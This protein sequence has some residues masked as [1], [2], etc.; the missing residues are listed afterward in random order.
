MVKEEGGGVQWRAE[1][2]EVDEEG[3]RA[4]GV[5]DYDARAAHIPIIRANALTFQD[6]PHIFFSSFLANYPPV[7][8]TA[9]RERLL[10]EMKMKLF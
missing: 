8:G 5:L 7:S 1:G 3:C 10:H 9:P 2:A 4:R 6:Q